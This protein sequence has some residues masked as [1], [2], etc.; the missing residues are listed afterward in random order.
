MFPV[1]P[2]GQVQLN[3]PGVFIHV[4]PFKQ[5]TG[6]SHSSI[7]EK[8]QNQIEKNTREKHKAARAQ[9]QELDFSV[10]ILYQK[11]DMTL[12]KIL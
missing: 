4:P 12:S 10:K 3:V 11:G 1:Q 2:G 7:S 9:L 5:F 8:K 6:S